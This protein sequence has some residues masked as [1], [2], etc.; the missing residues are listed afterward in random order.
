MITA[1]PRITTNFNKTC[2]NILYEWTTAASELVLDSWCR[3]SGLFDEWRLG[4]V[5]RQARLGEHKWYP[6]AHGM[7][8]WEEKC[9]SHQLQKYPSFVKPKYNW[10]CISSLDTSKHAYHP[11]SHALFTPSL[12]PFLPPHLSRI[13]PSNNPQSLISNVCKIFVLTAALSFINC[14][15][16]P[17]CAFSYSSL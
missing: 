13:H 7:L 17:S 9:N 3:Y 12:P 15:S 4:S 8:Y 10:I 14:V 11:F 2:W 1:L 5:K 16:P 6:G